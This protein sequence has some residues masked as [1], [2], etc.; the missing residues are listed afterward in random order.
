MKTCP[1]CGKPANLVMIMWI[2]KYYTA[3][4][5]VC[6]ACK[7]AWLKQLKKNR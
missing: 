7:R 3:T 5:K 1:W 4:E 2:A 6:P